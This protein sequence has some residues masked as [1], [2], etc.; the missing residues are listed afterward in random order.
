MSACDGGVLILWKTEVCF[1]A[2]GGNMA[3][4]RTSE[5]W[6]IRCEIHCHAGD[7]VFQAESFDVSEDGVSFLTDA[8][9]PL[10]SE[11]ILHYRPHPDDPLIVVRVLVRSQS[12]RRVGVK[13]LDLKHEHRET[14]RKHRSLAKTVGTSGS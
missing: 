3:E 6:P 10:N 9:L 12:G 1:A 7:Q 8:H 4:R 5:R 11:A 2:Y 13:F 14:L